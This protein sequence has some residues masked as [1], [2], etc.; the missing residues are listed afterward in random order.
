M[1]SWD[2][3]S[4]NEKEKRFKEEKSKKRLTQFKTLRR[5]KEREKERKKERKKCKKLNQWNG[6]NK[7]NDS[8]TLV[9]G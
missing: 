5:K 4:I 2:K 9:V 1:N 3:E 8:N 7:V 6:K